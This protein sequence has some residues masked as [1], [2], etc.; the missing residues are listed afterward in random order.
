MSDSYPPMWA[1]VCEGKRW[2]YA[3][4]EDGRVTRTSK[5]RHIE[6]R[7]KV[8]LHS[9]GHATVKINGSVRTLKNLIAKHFV[10]GWKPGMYVECIDGNQLNCAA[11]N[12][13]L[14]THSEH[15]KRTGWKSGKAKP[16]TA[17]GKRY[18]SYRECGK[19]MYAS[20]QTISDCISG[21]SRNSVLSGMGIAPVEE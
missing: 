18:A 7:V 3:V 2:I 13:R 12:L 21:R 20:Y 5:V 1:R 14:Y 6:T 4:C 15:G 11:W 17:N 9:R 10:K 16:V 8:F 19:A